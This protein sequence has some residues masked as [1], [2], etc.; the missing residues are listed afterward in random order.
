MQKKV[1]SLGQEKAELEEKLEK[2]ERKC[3]YLPVESEKQPDK[4]DKRK[5]K[6]EPS[7]MEKT[8]QKIVDI[9]EKI[10]KVDKK[11]ESNLPKKAASEYESRKKQDKICVVRRRI[12]N[13][14]DQI[15]NILGG[16]K[17]G[18]ENGLPRPPARKSVRPNESYRSY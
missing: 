17:T 5:E 12:S 11:I 13:T 10:Q 7:E 9:K 16:L 2:E 3:K 6:K 14:K 15:A 1:S 8:E 18:D 4:E